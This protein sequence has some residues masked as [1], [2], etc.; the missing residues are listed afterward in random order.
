MTDDNPVAEAA[1]DVAK[2]GAVASSFWGI[3]LIVLGALCI[4]APFVAGTF[5]TVMIAV[6]LIAAGIVTTM[7]AF[8]ADS[9]GIGIFA[10]LMG[11]ATALV[12]AYLLARP[13]LG[14][15]SITLA[16]AVWFVVDGAFQIIGAFRARRSKGWVWFL[17]GGIISIALGYMIISDW[18][19]SGAWVV[20]TL[21]GIRL[22]FG[23]W[24][25]VMLGSTQAA[26][27]DMLEN[28]E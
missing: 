26:V 9:W 2:A 22:V 25:I 23:G 8:R 24:T 28:P 16:L 5:T 17:I 20:G 7:G 18:P 14:M 3:A 27:A 21:V 13:M 10:V 6:A 12:G 19:F 15:V 11:V 4:G 1:A